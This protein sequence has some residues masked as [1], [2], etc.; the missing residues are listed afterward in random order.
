MILYEEL[1]SDSQKTFKFKLYYKRLIRFL[2]R[3]TIRMVAVL[4]ILLT[5]LFFSQKFIF[6]FLSEKPKVI[7]SHSSG[8][9]DDSLA[10][11]L[12]TTKKGVS[13]R[14]TKDGSA[15]VATSLEYRSP[16]FINR[17]VTIR[18]ALFKEGQLSGEIF[19]NTYIIGREF[20]LP[21]I[22]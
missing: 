10:L 5:F 8:I 22:T 9:Y 15:P 20:D 14:Y 18:A 19:T 4:A 13:I 1:E 6:F 17:P 12:S 21:V 7:F 11:V 2:R 3:Q 16:I